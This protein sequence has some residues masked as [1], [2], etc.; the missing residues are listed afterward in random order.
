MD[1]HQHPA[2][3]NMEPCWMCVEICLCH[4]S[5]DAEK[6]T[7]NK[8]ETCFQPVLWHPAKCLTHIKSITHNSPFFLIYGR[9]CANS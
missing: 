6:Q 1:S 3:F 7:D 5:A 4:K 2:N 9:Q 8:T